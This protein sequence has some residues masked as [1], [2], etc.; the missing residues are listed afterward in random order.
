MSCQ[1]RSGRDIMNVFKFLLLFCLTFIISNCCV[2]E[3]ERGKSLTI[4]LQTCLDEAVKETKVNGAVLLI[5]TP[6]FQWIGSSGY[7]DSKKT[8]VL[9]PS[10]KLRIASMT[11]TFVSVVVLK[12]AEEG[13][14]N[15]DTNI[16][17]YLPEPIISRIPYGYKI[18]IRQ[19]LN[20]TSGI[21]S[22]T[23]GVLIRSTAPLTFV[24]LTAS[25]KQV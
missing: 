1:Q 18:T 12:L 15:L 2:A 24:S 11:K 23:E 5:K 6:S 22:Y 3:T 19:L 25:S 20:M 13:K 16:K 8:T 7:T 10:D 4:L 21:R 9:K 14:L 17:F